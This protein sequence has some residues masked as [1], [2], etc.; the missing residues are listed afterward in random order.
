MLF[1]PK[2]PTPDLYL[3]PRPADK[4]AMKTAEDGGVSEFIEVSAEIIGR[5]GF[6]TRLTGELARDLTPQR[7]HTIDH[8]NC[9]SCPN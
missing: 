3:V 8:I 4:Q 2:G 9:P 6:D 1:T 5:W 7:G